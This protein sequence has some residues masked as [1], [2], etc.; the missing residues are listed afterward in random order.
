[1]IKNVMFKRLII[2][3]LIV[4]LLFCARLPGASADTFYDTFVS[5]CEEQGWFVSFINSKFIEKGRR[6]T[7]S[8]LADDPVLLEI[9]SLEVPASG[10]EK[11]PQAVQ[12]LPNLE[13]VD[14]SY[15]RISDVSPLYN[16]GG[17]KSLKLGG[18][19]ISE[20]D[21]SRF[22]ALEYAYLE[23]NRFVRMP[24][25]SANKSLSHIDLSGNS[26]KEVKSFAGLGRVNY[27]SLAGN[28]IEDASVLGTFTMINFENPAAIDLSYN[29]LKNMDFAKNISGVKQIDVSY[30]KIEKAVVSS[31][32][33]SLDV[34]YNKLP[35]LSGISGNTV[36]DVLRAAG[37][38]ITDL[39][40]I[41]ACVNL[42][43]LDLSHN[44]IDD[45]Y[46]IYNLSKLRSVDLSYNKMTELFMSSLLTVLETLDI[47]HNEIENIVL[48]NRYQSLVNIDASH[49]KLTDVNVINGLSKLVFAD[50]SYNSITGISAELK[51]TTKK[52]NK[53]DLSGNP[54]T[55][56]D[57]KNLFANSYPEI[58]L[59]EI[60]LSGK[61]PDMSEYDDIYELY[62]SGSTVSDADISNIFLKDDYT[63]LGLGGI[64]STA[65]IEK[66]A[67]QH[68][69]IKLDVSNTANVSQFIESIASLNILELDISNCGI[70]QFS[71]KLVQG[72]IVKINVSQNALTFVPEEILKVAVKKGIN[73]DFSY[74][75]ISD[76]HEF[77]GYFDG[78]GLD[79]AGNM[80]LQ[81]NY[82]WE[83]LTQLEETSYIVGSRFNVYPT[84]KIQNRYTGQIASVPPLSEFE[85]SVSN[86]DTTKTAL[87]I[88]DEGIFVTVND[89]IS[90]AEEYNVRIGIKNS[91]KT[92]LAFAVKVYT[93][94]SIYPEMNI[95]GISAIY[96]IEVGTDFSTLVQNIGFDSTLTYEIYTSTGEVAE[97]ENIV[98]TGARVIV[99]NGDTVIYDKYTI[100]YGDC[101]GDGA[102]N[103]IDVMVVKRHIFK[104]AII[105]GIYLEA[106]DNDDN[107]MLNVI[108]VMIIKRHIFKQTMIEQK[109]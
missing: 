82:G 61:I 96:G 99:K 5:L 4:S 88:T 2:S 46:G 26:I 50:F 105:S 67:L 6:F 68:A 9:T 79:F 38:A 95:D 90:L 40:D 20:I 72:N 94:S 77:Y 31:S 39:E 8:V 65:I 44:L 12:F 102:I 71:E 43:V 13:S 60:N 98:G 19:N 62:I 36:L 56:Q 93:N 37:N 91:K 48:L 33:T 100:V 107:E 73:I 51:N 59:E 45:T 29:M 78:V 106:A 85:V 86:G 10:I 21:L 108:D 81:L 14:L 83:M 49:N 55:A 18:N 47:S 101:N 28:E 57:I 66:L 15:N 25:V 80:M 64:L 34:S 17:I 35:D 16:C 42:R 7:D 53:I 75:E 24:T 92:S 74:N 30:N 97:A 109:R 41:S 52:L 22:E 54:L 89:S 70:T 76:G 11:I 87:E 104:Q 23:N 1:M 69:L 84:I 63:G 103:V 58:W 32:V 27:I 3:L